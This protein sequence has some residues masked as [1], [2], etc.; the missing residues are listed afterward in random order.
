MTNKLKPEIVKILKEF[1]LDPREA[2]WDCHGSWILLHI[3]L[4]KQ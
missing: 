2:L 3:S 4:V 1:G